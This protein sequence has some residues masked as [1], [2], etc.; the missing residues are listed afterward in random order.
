VQYRVLRNIGLMRTGAILIAGRSHA[1]EQQGATVTLKGRVSSF[2]GT[3]PSLNFRVEGRSVTTD[4]RT[5]FTDGT[6]GDMR[7]GIEVEIDG[8]VQSTG[9]IYA[10]N[11]EVKQ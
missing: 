2:S 3:C 9:L 7:N 5:K 10:I 1:I 4:A 8:E 11:I 6:C